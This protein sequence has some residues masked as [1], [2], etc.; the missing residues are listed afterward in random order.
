M[1]FFSTTEGPE[2]DPTWI[3]SLRTQPLRLFM[4]H[5]LELSQCYFRPEIAGALHPQGAKA[6]HTQMID[7]DVEKFQQSSRVLQRFTQGFRRA[8]DLMVGAV[9][10]APQTPAP[11]E[12]AALVHPDASAEADQGE[13]EKI[14]EARDVQVSAFRAECEVHSRT[15]SLLVPRGEV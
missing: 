1:Q 13:A 14:A 10:E 15:P 3:Q 8:Y 4:K 9:Q 6:K 2:R 5:V 11:E 12:S 7:Y